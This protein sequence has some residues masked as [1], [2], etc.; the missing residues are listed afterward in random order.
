[1]C[2]CVCVC[3]G[4]C[5]GVCV[6]ACGFLI[7]TSL[8]CCLGSTYYTSDVVLLGACK[9]NREAVIDFEPKSWSV[10]TSLPVTPVTLTRS[11]HRHSVMQNTD[12]VVVVVVVVVVAAV[13]Q[14]KRESLAKPLSLS[15]ADLTSGLVLDVSRLWSPSSSRCRGDAGLS[16]LQAGRQAGARRA[17]PRRATDETA[18]DGGRQRGALCIT[19]SFDLTFDLTGLLKSQPHSQRLAYRKAILQRESKSASGRGGAGG[20]MDGCAELFYQQSTGG[21]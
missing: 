5:V 4:V 14:I 1:V 10:D 12:V 7:K 2:V 16:S 19:K 20:R 18:A 11:S 21:T 9:Y 15:G 3:V 13:T 6:R 8:Q 17:P